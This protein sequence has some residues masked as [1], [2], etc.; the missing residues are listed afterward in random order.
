M[1]ERLPA[2]REDHASPERMRYYGRGMI[3]MCGMG[4]VLVTVVMV[5]MART[6]LHGEDLGLLALL[7]S[8]QAFFIVG[9]A[10]ASFSSAQA[11]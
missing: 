8:V 9:I 10:A 6:F 7:A 3:T 1:G 11:G 2:L 5:A 4:V